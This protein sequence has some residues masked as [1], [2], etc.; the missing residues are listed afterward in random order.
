VLAV[1]VVAAALAA[2]GCGGKQQPVRIGVLSDCE[3]GLN[4]LYQANLSGAVLPLLDRGARLLGDQPSDGVSEITVGGRRVRLVLGCGGSTST[5]AV[6]EARR[7]VEREQIDVLVGPAFAEAL[8]VKQY[9]A[10]R[11]DVVFVSACCAPPSATLRDPLPNFFNF[12][13]DESQVGAGLGAYGFRQGWRRAVIIGQDE[14]IGWSY[15]AGIV[16][17]FCA[18]GGQIVKRI[19]ESPLVDPAV[20][21]DQVPKQGVDGIFYLGASGPQILALLNGLPLFKGGMAG[22]LL[23]QATPFVDPS[24]SLGKRAEGAI[25]STAGFNGNPGSPGDRY[26]AVLAKRFPKQFRLSGLLAP[27]AGFGLAYRNGMEAVLEAL[28]RV[29]GDLSGGKHRFMA[30]LAKVE[31]DAPNGHI[32]LDENRALIGPNYLNR[33]TLNTA[34]KFEAHTF[35]KFP[36]IDQ[37]FGGLITPDSPP[38]GRTTPACRRG[39]VPPWARS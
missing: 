38:A 36:E 37:T 2:F 30:E 39:P 16:A 27:A 3:G 28:E 6:A 8:A 5:S 32:R 34:G 26:T 25:Y 29:S 19:W 4:F 11:P 14:S 12:A 7:L 22:K 33:L 24:Q 15:A 1:A 13:L 21:V 23:S 20:I 10:T 9:A 18:L 31:L 17:E 35:V